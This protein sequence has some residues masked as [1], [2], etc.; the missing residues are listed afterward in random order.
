MPSDTTAAI[1]AKNGSRCSKTS[2]ASHHATPAAIAH[3]PMTQPLARSRATRARSDVRLRSAIRSASGRRT[4]R[5]SDSRLV[6]AH[7]DALALL[8]PDHLVGVRGADTSEL[9][10]VERHIAASA[11]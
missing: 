2:A 7:Q 10:G 6:G 9:G 8:A 3:W 5:L 4:G 1:G 11:L